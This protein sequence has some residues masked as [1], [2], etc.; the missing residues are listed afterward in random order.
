MLLQTLVLIYIRFS[1][2]VAI[3]PT[4]FVKTRTSFASFIIQYIGK[5]STTT[6]L[7]IREIQEFTCIVPSTII[8]NVVAQREK[9]TKG[10]HDHINHRWFAVAEFSDQVAEVYFAQ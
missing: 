8:L 10:P 4:H 9:V 3:V 1:S 7:K 5:P 2:L 6:S